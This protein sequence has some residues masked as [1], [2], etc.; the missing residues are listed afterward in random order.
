MSSAVRKRIQKKF[1]IRGY[2]L[3]I[4]ALDPILSFTNRFLGAE[5]EALDLLLDHLQSQSQKL[6]VKSSILDKEPVSRVIASLLAADDAVEED[7]IS[8][9]AVS[10]ST[11]AI[12]V[13]DAF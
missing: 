8:D 6:G 10:S 9:G 12:R 7:F 5:D 2:T 11:S 4:D 1:K 3:R 13:I